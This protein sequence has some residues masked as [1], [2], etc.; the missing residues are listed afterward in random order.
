LDRQI[1]HAGDTTDPVSAKSRPGKN[2]RFAEDL[3]PADQACAAA[4]PTR[5]DLLF[6]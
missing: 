6:G 4:A 3:S 5:L 2:W 1:L